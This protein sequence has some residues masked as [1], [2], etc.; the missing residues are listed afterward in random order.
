[1][2]KYFM[3]QASEVCAFEALQA[4]WFGGLGLDGFRGCKATAPMLV[5]ALTEKTGGV[6]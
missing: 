1:M 4:F 2:A 6:A 3:F 5:K